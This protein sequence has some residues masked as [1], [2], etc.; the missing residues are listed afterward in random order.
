MLYFISTS[1]YFEAFQG[2]ISVDTGLGHLAAALGV[3]ALSIYGPTD[4]ELI[5]T[6]GKKINSK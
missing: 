1:F 4:I 2:V 3:P 5:G 6:R